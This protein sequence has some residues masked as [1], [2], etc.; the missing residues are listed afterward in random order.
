V[1]DKGVPVEVPLVDLVVA[2]L[3]PGADGVLLGPLDK[4]TKVA[5][6]GLGAGDPVDEGDIGLLRGLPLVAHVHVEH[7]AGN[8]ALVLVRDFESGGG[9]IGVN[10]AAGALVWVDAEEAAAVFV[11]LVV[12]LVV[13]AL[14]GGAEMVGIVVGVRALGGKT[15]GLGPAM[16]TVPCNNLSSS[17][18]VGLHQ[19]KKKEKKREEKVSDLI[20]QQGIHLIFHH[21]FFFS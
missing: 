9:L 6:V 2:C 15:L 8:V 10:L 21:L 4:V 19:K 16:L 20:Q 1:V 12:A 5:K 18:P 7:H 3:L 17:V 13:D 14:V 11:V